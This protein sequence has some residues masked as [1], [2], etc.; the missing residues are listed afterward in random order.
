VCAD[1]DV[2]VALL[3]GADVVFFDRPGTG[4]SPPLS[5]A[6][7]RAA[8]P[9]LVEEVQLISDV[10]AAAGTTPPYVLVGHSSGGLYAQ[11]FARTHPDRTAGLVLVDSSL[12]RANSGRRRTGALRRAVARAPMPGLLGPTIR[13]MLVWSQTHHGVDPL[14]PAER[15][16]I[17]RSPAVLRAIL[18]ELDGFD[19]AARQL[20]GL[21]AVPLPRVPITVVAAGSTGRPWPRRDTASLGEQAGL[22]RLLGAGVFRQVDD[23]AHLVPLDRPDV[24]AREIHTVLRAVHDGRGAGARKG[25]VRPAPGHPRK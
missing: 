13:R 11:A 10:C 2:V 23:A 24:V 5:R 22:A 14:P 6:W 8:P 4:H 7:P 17:Y 12:P 18:A 20:A 16:Q 9:T 1:W 25:D 15:R 19:P 21:A 3:P